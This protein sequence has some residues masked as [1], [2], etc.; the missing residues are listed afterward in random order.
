MISG[1]GV[2]VDVDQALANSTEAK[3][4]ISSGLVCE[5]FR[6]FFN[7]TQVGIGSKVHEEMRDTTTDGSLFPTREFVQKYFGDGIETH[8]DLRF[9]LRNW[10]RN[11]SE[12]RLKFNAFCRLKFF[13]K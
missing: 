10:Y 3:V 13:T 1:V 8:M 2:G 9:L 5:N 7:F 11:I 6:Q 4:R 12:T